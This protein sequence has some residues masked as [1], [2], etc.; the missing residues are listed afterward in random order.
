MLRTIQPFP[1]EADST[2]QTML[3]YKSVLWLFF[4]WFCFLF[5]YGLFPVFTVHKPVVLEEMVHNLDFCDI[6]VIGVELDPRQ[7][8]L[9]LD[10]KEHQGK[11]LDATNS[12]AGYSIYG[13]LMSHLHF[14]YILKRKGPGFCL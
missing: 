12:T 13:M 6:L 11:H 4:L 14:N 9:E 1:L 5:L 10:R 2:V 7:E 3:K 8:C